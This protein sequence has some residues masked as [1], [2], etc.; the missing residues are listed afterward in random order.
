M[1]KTSTAVK[2][3]RNGEYGKALA[4]FSTF[5]NGFEKSEM[6]SIE[7]ACDCL[8][9]HESFYNQLGIDTTKEYETAIAVINR[10][11]KNYPMD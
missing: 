4:I 9:G 6:R 5:K 7:I 11:Y 1:T 8:H 3:F 2:L 10:R